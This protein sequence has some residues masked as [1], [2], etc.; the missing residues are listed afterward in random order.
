LRVPRGVTLREPGIVA[1]DLTLCVHDPRIRNRRREDPT[2]A[3]AILRYAWGGARRAAGRIGERRT[4]SNLRVPRKTDA[5]A[6]GCPTPAP[7]SEPRLDPINSKLR[8]S[9]KPQWP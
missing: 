1:F 6:D 3:L 7:A 9:D 5:G 8:V 4:D 2:V